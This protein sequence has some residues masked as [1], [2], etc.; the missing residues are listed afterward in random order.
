MEIYRLSDIRWFSWVEV[1]IQLND[2]WSSVHGV[3][4]SDESFAEEARST[5]KELIVEARILNLRSELG[6]IKDVGYPMIILCYDQ[7]GDSFLS[8]TTYDHWKTTVNTIVNIC[9]PTTNLTPALVSA[10][11]LVAPPHSTAGELE[12]IRIN[13]ILKAHLVKDKL[14]YD[15]N[16]RLR[17]S[18]VTLRSCRLIN[19]QFVSTIPLITL[20]QEFHCLASLPYAADFQVQMTVEL[21]KY[22]SLADLETILQGDEVKI[23]LWEFWIKHQ[24]D[25][26]SL[27]LGALEAALIMPSLALQR[28]YSHS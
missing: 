5:M 16:N 17:S 24:L 21:A 26:P 3:L 6:L 9:N 13:T 10:I 23:G 8:P 20:E 4:F 18:L 1:A 2:N 22:K 19:Y 11:Q 28:E 14:I 12:A 7:E 15:E 25:I 27:F